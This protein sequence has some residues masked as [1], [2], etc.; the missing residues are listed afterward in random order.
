MN[1]VTFKNGITI[2]ATAFPQ[3]KIDS[4]VY[5]EMLNDLTD[6]RY[7]HAIY[8]IVRTNNEIYQ[9]TNLISLIR[10]KA[11]ISSVSSSEEAWKEVR[12]K[13]IS[14]GRYNRPVFS[15]ELIENAVN[16]MGWEDFCKSD[17]SQINIYK[18]HFIKAYEQ[19]KKRSDH[20]KK[21]APKNINIKRL[22]QT[23]IKKVE[24]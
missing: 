8:D 5:Y 6:E 10:D 17:E 22:I 2:L 13:A 9:T 16:C 20:E 1:I 12:N 14:V 7:L 24:A 19:I 23:A 11:I 4:E 18:S 3:Y 21:L 15:N